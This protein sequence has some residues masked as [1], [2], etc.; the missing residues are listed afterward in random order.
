M[1]V[2]L[3]QWLLGSTPTPPWTQLGIVKVKL[4]G[5]DFYK[6]SGLHLDCY[7]TTESILHSPSSELEYTISWTITGRFSEIVVTDYSVLEVWLHRINSTYSMW[8]FNLDCLVLSLGLFQSWIAEFAFL[9]APPPI[10]TYG[11]QTLT[12]ADAVYSCCSIYLFP[13][14][15]FKQFVV[16][17]KKILLIATMHRFC[18]KFTFVEINK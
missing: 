5:P 3:T 9:S 4:N 10:Q 17:E 11:Q 12:Q 8:H 16:K 13:F 15:H 2:H 14:F 1:Y 7:H 18:R 6:L